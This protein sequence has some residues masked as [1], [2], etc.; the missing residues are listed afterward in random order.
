LPEEKE[1]NAREFLKEF[2]KI[3][4]RGRGLDIIP[5]R[6]TMKALADLGL[7]KNNLKEEIMAL[8]VEDYC[9]GPA[10]DRDRAGDIWIFGKQ[11]FGKEIYIKLK[12]AQ[13]GEEKIAKCL[14]FHPSSYPLC[15]PCR[16][17]KRR[18][19]K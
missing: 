19:D 9:E 5:R 15:F 8:S 18:D 2:K 14:S 7:T 11:I 17:K 1:T 12:I 13:V 4:V 6:E 16:A 3:M 10:P